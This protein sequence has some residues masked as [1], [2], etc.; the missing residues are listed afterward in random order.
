MPAS[1][2]PFNEPDYPELLEREEDLARWLQTHAK[3]DPSSPNLPT[4]LL[5]YGNYDSRDDSRTF[6]RG[7]PDVMEYEDYDDEPSVNID[8][9]LAALPEVFAKSTIR[10]LQMADAYGEEIAGLVQSP[11]IAG[12]RGLSLHDLADHENST[13]A[14]AIR[15]I[16]TSPHLRSSVAPP[17]FCYQ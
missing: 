3:D 9:I 17:R 2:W 5:W 12:L 7:F 13:E 6:S 14:D 16:A 1:R 11:V 10:T 8:R 4:D 15:G